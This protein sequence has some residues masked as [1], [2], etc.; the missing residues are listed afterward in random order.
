MPS[1]ITFFYLPQS[2]SKIIFTNELT[3]PD[4]H[5]RL[6]VVHYK[7]RYKSQALPGQNMHHLPHYRDQCT[8]AQI[9]SVQKIH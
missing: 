8:N 3:F 1:K 2:E 7:I 9:G 6:P 5:S 4:T